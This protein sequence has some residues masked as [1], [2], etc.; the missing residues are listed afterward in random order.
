[1]KI[2][3]LPSS[4]SPSPSS[5]P[6]TTITPP[7]QPQEGETPDYYVTHDEYERCL[8]VLT[9]MDEFRPLYSDKRRWIDKHGSIK[10]WKDMQRKMQHKLEKHE[11]GIPRE[12][13]EKGIWGLAKKLGDM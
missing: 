4:P 10:G 13:L 2:A 12:E 11:V 6:S 7:Q 8:L 1:M 5:S 3:I 9:K